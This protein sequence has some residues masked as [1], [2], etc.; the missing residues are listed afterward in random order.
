MV[1]ERQIIDAVEECLSGSVVEGWQGGGLE[2]WLG[3]GMVEDMPDDGVV[4][5][6]RAMVT[7]RKKIRLFS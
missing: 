4:E 3:G 7:G 6:G 5:G 2:G 1:D